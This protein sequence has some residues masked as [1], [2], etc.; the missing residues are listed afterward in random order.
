M[1]RMADLGRFPMSAEFTDLRSRIIVTLDWM[2]D[3][4]W[5]RLLE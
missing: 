1:K 2:A 4:V 3:A 5:P